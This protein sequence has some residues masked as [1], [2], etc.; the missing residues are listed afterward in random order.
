MLAKTY[1]VFVFKVSIQLDL[2]AIAKT[3]YFEW[4][5]SIQIIA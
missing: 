1:I 3:Q 2:L 5:L 4:L